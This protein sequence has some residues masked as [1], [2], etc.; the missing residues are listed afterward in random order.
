ME[1]KEKETAGGVGPGITG[2]SGELIEGTGH[3]QGV[4]GTGHDDDADAAGMRAQDE[5]TARPD[6]REAEADASG[7]T[8]STRLSGS[9]SGSVGG[10]GP[11]AARASGDTAPGRPGGGRIGTRRPRAA[12][13][14]R[15]GQVAAASA[16]LAMSRAA[17]ATSR[18]RMTMPRTPITSTVDPGRT[19]RSGRTTFA[20]GIPGRTTSIRWWE[21]RD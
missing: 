9:A 20:R 17:F 16:R 8:A 14:L 2:A 6:A 1:P 19:D 13:L 5:Y 12:T 18:Q 21:R 11:N 15:G 7:N 4:G 10:G 3:D